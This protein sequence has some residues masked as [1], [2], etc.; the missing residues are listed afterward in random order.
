MLRLIVIIVC[1]GID[2]EVELRHIGKRISEVYS[3]SY[4]FI[5]HLVSRILIYLLRVTV[6]DV[7]LIEDICIKRITTDILSAIKS[8]AVTHLLRVII[9]LKRHSWREFVAILDI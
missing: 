1:R 7:G 2:R 9:K 4:I 6:E 3:H 8:D 5:V